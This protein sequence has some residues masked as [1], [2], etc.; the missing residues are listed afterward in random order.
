MLAAFETHR[1]LAL[2]VVPE[3]TRR[4]IEFVTSNHS[5]LSKSTVTISLVE[6]KNSLNA[7][8]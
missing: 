3:A 8:E 1:Y 4:T 2:T 6:L 7:R 5:G